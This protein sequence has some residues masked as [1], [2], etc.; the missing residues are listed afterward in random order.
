MII[1]KTK[2]SDVNFIMLRLLFHLQEKKHFN[3]RIKLI[4]QQLPEN[5]TEK[6]IFSIN[7]V[8]KCKSVHEPMMS[9]LHGVLLECI[10]DCSIGVF[11]F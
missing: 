5:L 1:R 11:Q 9:D 10:I 8:T 2:F 3:S 4:K 7:Y 6:N